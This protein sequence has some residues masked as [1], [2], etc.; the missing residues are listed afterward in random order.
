MAN[1][2]ILDDISLATST[3]ENYI[4]TS[5][6]TRST[7][8]TSTF[9]LVSCLK[10]FVS[11]PYHNA[12]L[13]WQVYDESPSIKSESLSESNDDGYLK[14]QTKHMPLDTSLLKTWSNLIYLPTEGLSSPWK[15]ITIISIIAYNRVFNCTHK[16]R[17]LLYRR[18]LPF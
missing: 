13:L 11:V 14:E 12:Y 2:S 16:G 7:A 17:T 3:D 10:L 15:G 9:F 4:D 6:P 18:T 1:F 5:P 8:S